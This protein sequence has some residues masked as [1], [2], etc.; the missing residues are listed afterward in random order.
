MALRDGH[1]RAGSVLVI[2]PTAV[3]TVVQRTANLGCR[4]VSGPVVAAVLLHLLSLYLS[5]YYHV[6]TPEDTEMIYVFGFR[7]DST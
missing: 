4:G 1:L 6:I 5:P 7:M 2:V 3:G